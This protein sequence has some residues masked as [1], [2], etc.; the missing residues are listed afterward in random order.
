M[1]QLYEILVS[2]RDEASRTF[3]RVADNAAKASK[4]V[5]ASAAAAYENDTRAFHA[6]LARERVAEL[7]R[8]QK[9]AAAGG[10]GLLKGLKSQFGEESSLGLG[11]KTL[12]G[13]GAVAGVSALTGALA[14]AAEN[15]AELSKKY[16][17]GKVSGEDMFASIVKGIPIL[18]DLK[19][20]VDATGD[21]MLEF[22]GVS[23]QVRDLT[24]A[25][26]LGGARFNPE[27]AR[28][29]AQERSAADAAAAFDARQAAEAKGGSPVDQAIAR[30]EA[31]FQQE[32][33]EIESLREKQAAADPTRDFQSETLDR[34]IKAEQDFQ[35]DVREIR[36]KA[37]DVE[38][39]RRVQAKEK[40]RADFQKR[41]DEALAE[42][43]QQQAQEARQL[44]DHTD[45]MA[46]IREAANDAVSGAGGFLNSAINFL[47]SIRG[48]PGARDPLTDGPVDPSFSLNESRRL[49]GVRGQSPTQDVP[50]QQ[51]EEAKKQTDVLETVAGFMG[52]LLE[53]A[54]AG[55]VLFA[56]LR[57][58]SNAG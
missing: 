41:R 20:T 27:T 40:A 17:E 9:E 36:Q 24:F 2:A 43:A 30:R 1:P 14:N 58:S 12:L 42:E 47:G 50:R 52:E 26:E 56:N 4:R 35:A 29:E 46:R 10:G 22:I 15:M 57:G 28:R 32:L 31:Q 54:K 51:F 45:R 53:R 37:D 18:G 38:S 23:K 39:T 11:V 8:T 48:G 6:F 34:Q 21:A 33:R 7:N 19:R 5:S 44:A 13:A 3:D 55:N 16:T 25:E 49:T